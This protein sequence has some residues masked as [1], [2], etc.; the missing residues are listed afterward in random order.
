MSFPTLSHHDL[1]ISPDKKK[2]DTLC[3]KCGH[4]E[5]GTLIRRDDD[6]GEPIGFHHC[7]RFELQL[8][9]LGLASPDEGCKELVRSGLNKYALPADQIFSTCQG[10]YFEPA[11]LKAGKAVRAS[12]NLPKK[13]NCEYC[14]HSHKVASI[15]SYGITYTLNNCDCIQAQCTLIQQTTPIEK[16][17]PGPWDREKYVYPTNLVRP[18][19]KGQYFE[20]HML[21]FGADEE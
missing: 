15:W 12:T 1:G 11:D 14:N 2:S 21:M 3:E 13:W 16:D 20:P 19:C 9:H 10:M 17:S 5:N 18:F 6:V 8:E 7:N 4:C